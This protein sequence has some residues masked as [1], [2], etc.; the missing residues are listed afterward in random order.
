MVAMVTA[1]LNIKW[2]AWP[3]NDVFYAYIVGENIF[4]EGKHLE[5]YNK[6]HKN[7]SVLIGFKGSSNKF[8]YGRYREII[9]VGLCP[10]PR[11]I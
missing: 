8:L 5:K 3:S 7:T 1:F 6:N 11:D 9:M 4:M 10:T 2:P